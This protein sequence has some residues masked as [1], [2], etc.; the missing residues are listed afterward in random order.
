M[1]ESSQSGHPCAFCLQLVGPSDP[2]AVV[3]LH[4]G[5]RAPPHLFAHARCLQVA[6][7]PLLRQRLDPDLARPVAHHPPHPPNP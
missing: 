1:S 3:S 6:V 4:T 2:L 5:E 7:H